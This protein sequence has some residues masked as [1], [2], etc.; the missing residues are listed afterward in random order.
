MSETLNFVEYDP[1]N[2]QHQKCATALGAWSCREQML[3][4]SVEKMATHVVGPLAFTEETGELVGYRAITQRYQSGDREWL[5]LGGLV[6][7][8]AERGRGYGRQIADAIFALA[9]ERYPDSSFVVFCNTQSL[10]LSLRHGF[11]PASSLDE[12][13]SEAFSLCQNC[14]IKQSGQLQAGKLCCD[15]IV[16][17]PA[18]SN[19]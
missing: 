7:N 13:P 6:V 2:P 1:T 10:P 16:V 12:I 14:P 8:P 15:T 17:L 19:E 3:P 5:E 11:T 9:K 4:L 18:G